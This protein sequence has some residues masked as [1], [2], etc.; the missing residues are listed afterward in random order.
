MTINEKTR[1]LPKEYQK[2]YVIT[3]PQEDLNNNTGEIIVSKYE[4]YALTRDE[5]AKYIQDPYWKR[6]RRICFSLYWIFCLIALLS[7]FYIAVEAIEGGFCDVDH[8][9]NGYP[10]LNNATTVPPTTNG[11]AA[12]TTSDNDSVILR[13]M[14]QPT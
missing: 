3:I 13:I 8:V 1:L 7:S 14:D 5:L 11:S 4:T 9:G 12:I 10:V 6:V 2:S